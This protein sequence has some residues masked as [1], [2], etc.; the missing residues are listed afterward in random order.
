MAYA[1]NAPGNYTVNIGANAIPRGASIS[2]TGAIS[3]TP[4]T[5]VIWNDDGI[6]I[7][8]DPNSYWSASHPTRLT[9]PSGFTAGAVFLLSVSNYEDGASSTISFKKNGSSVIQEFV[10]NSVYGGMQGIVQLATGDYI[11]VFDS[12][13]TLLAA[14]A[15]FAIQPLTLT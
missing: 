9:V 10:V 13:G 11:E 14:N 1:G 8:Y 12:A 6:T 2:N 15:I 3:L 4:G 5:A 7:N